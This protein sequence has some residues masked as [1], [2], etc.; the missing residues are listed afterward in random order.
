MQATINKFWENTPKE[1]RLFIAKA[2]VIFIVWQI[3][4]LVFLVPSRLVDAPLSAFTGNATA[5]SINKILNKES[6]YSK[7]V[8]VIERKYNKTQKV[9]RAYVFENENKILGIADGCNGLSLFVL[10]LGFIFI[11]PSNLKLKIVYGISGILLLIVVNILRCAGL[12]ILEIKH[13]E[14]TDFAHHYLFNLIAYSVVFSLW[15]V[16]S[17]VATKQKI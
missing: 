17:K 15:I 16:F 14:Y 3:V 1:V 8:E 12:G 6:V 4:Y 7:E 2:L 11:Y 9:K 13:P 5:W 10:F